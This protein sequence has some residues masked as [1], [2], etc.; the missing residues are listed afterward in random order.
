MARNSEQ[1]TSVLESSLGVSYE[2]VA[3]A[4]FLWSFDLL[5]ALVRHG[6]RHAV[7]S[8]GSRCAPLVLAASRVRGLR[9]WTHPDERSA[10]FLGLGIGKAT[11][12]PAA[13]ICTS[14]TAAANYFPAVIEANLSR[15]PM[16]LLTADR[17]PELRHRGAPQTIDQIDLYGRYALYFC[18]LPVPQNGDAA[19]SLWPEVAVNAFE[20]AAGFPRG[21]VHLNV[22]FREPLILDPDYWQTLYVAF[23]DKASELLDLC[24]SVWIGDTLLILFDIQ[25]N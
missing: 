20:I 22:P 11:Q 2:T 16:I 24:V 12:N 23:I 14:G 5:T 25:S 13:L 15:T 7:V 6:V 4:N 18:D 8:S 21:P 3:A 17:P 19:R 10:G 9:I 1:G